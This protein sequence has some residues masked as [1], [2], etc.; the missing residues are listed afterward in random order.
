MAIGCGP[1][2]GFYL[3]ARLQTGIEE[4]LDSRMGSRA[5]FV[6]SLYAQAAIMERAARTSAASTSNTLIATSCSVSINLAKSF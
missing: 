3:I 2:L 6:S 4:H 5:R 1:Y